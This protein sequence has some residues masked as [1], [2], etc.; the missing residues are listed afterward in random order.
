TASAT[1]VAA[2]NAGADTVRAFR[3]GEAMRVQWAKERDDL[4]IGRAAIGRIQA[5]QASWTTLINVLLTAAVTAIGAVL[6]L[7]GD[8][9]VGAMF[10]ATFLAARALQPVAR[11]GMMAE[12]FGRAARALREVE[13]LSRLPTEADK[14]TQLAAYKGRVEFKDLAFAFGGSTGPLF[15]SFDL[16]VQPG[17]VVVVVGP[18]G[19]GK[20]TLARLLMGLLEPTRGQIL[21]DGVDL[22]QIAPDWWRRQ[23]SY[24]PQEPGF[25]P[26]TVGFNI[27]VAR[28]EID[29]E[30]LGRIL[31]AADLKTWLD[32][33][34]QGL[35]AP[36]ADLGRSLSPG[37]RR[38]LA[39]ARALV[40]DGPL[41]LIDEPQDGLDAA[42][43]AAMSWL[44]NDL[45]A[46]GRTIFVFCHDPKLVAGADIIIDLGKKPVPDIRPNAKPPVQVAGVR[47]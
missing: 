31:K 28:P 9:S 35:G 13:A 44:L 38:R 2:G 8:I 4:A 17:Q 5:G 25:V 37:I 11:A 30:H 1:L 12:T 43:I 32:G 26:G 18:N 7:R 27:V 36:L 29:D 23:A 24:V 15:E 39:L 10:G 33:T 14:G 22:R 6:V 40:V 3:A 20:T 34:P 19:S 41:I 47:P 45:R 16:A 46:R 42:G 21:V